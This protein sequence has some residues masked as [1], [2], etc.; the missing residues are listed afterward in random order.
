MTKKLAELSGSVSV[1]SASL[2]LVLAILVSP[3]H[4]PSIP[5][6]R[7]TPS[8]D[9]IPSA[10]EKVEM[11]QE[12]SKTAPIPAK[13]ELSAKKADI[14][15]AP[16][17]SYSKA[18]YGLDKDAYAQ[19]GR[20]MM[21]SVL[22]VN[23]SVPNFTVTASVSPEEYDMILYCV[24]HETRSGSLPHKILI[25]EVIF[26]RVQGPKFGSSVR[27]VVLAPGQFDVMVNYQGWGDW[28]PDET[29]LQAV[30]LV[31]SGSAPDYSEG[32]V[33]FCN[34]YIVGEGNWFDMTRR[35]VCEIE[36]HRFYK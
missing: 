11:E 9:E 23:Q 5:A 30:N 28:V 24:G 27:D 21:S 22:A 16:V 2:I 34:P 31:L 33:Y 14:Y 25:T 13:E 32:A 26:N 6:F 29:T 19:S 10:P 18:I 4:L 17:A 35:V 20:D 7:Q 36:G 15:G 3:V 12:L 1:L 8:F